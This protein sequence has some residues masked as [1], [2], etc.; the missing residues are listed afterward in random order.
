[1]RKAEGCLGD[2]YIAGHRD[3]GRAGRVIAAL[4]VTRGNDSEAFVFNRDLR[5]AK[6]MAR[7]VKADGNAIDLNH[8]PELDALC[9]LAVICAVANGHNVESLKCWH[10]VD[11]AGACVVGMAMSNQRTLNGA[12]WINE[13]ITR[14]AIEAL[15]RWSQQLLW[16]HTLTLTL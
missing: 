5:R 14:R 15:G 13:K 11:M 12:R 4:I 3:I 7:G 2:K 6:N 1:H 16:L 10:N 8:F 9:R